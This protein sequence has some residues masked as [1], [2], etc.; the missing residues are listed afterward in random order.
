M[1]AHLRAW[2]AHRQGLDGSLTG[3]GPA[4]VLARSGWARS[5]GSS[6]PYLTLF[7]RAGIAREAVD[8]EV[9]KL[10]LCEL[11]S[12]RGCTYVLPSDD[13]ALAL[14]VAEASTGGRD[15]KT[16]LSLGATAAEIDRL[17]VKVVD[18]LAR[19][20][21]DPDGIKQACGAA[22]RNFGEAGKKKG[23]LTT[24]P[25]ALGRLQ[26]QGHIRRVPANGRLD[27]QRFRYSLWKPNPLAKFK[28]P[29][30]ECYTQL[31]RK[32]WS[33]IGPASMAEFQ[34][35][36]GL[37]VKA[38]QQAVAP[39][40]LLP[41]AAGS[42]RLLLAEHLDEFRTFKVPKE[43]Q[44]SLVS[45]LDALVLLRR[46]HTDLCEAGDAQ[47]P[48]LRS[49]ADLPSHAI[50][51]RGRLIGLW[52]YDTEKE[53]LAWMCF[54]KPGQQL[55]AAVTRTEEYIRTQLG[56]VRSFSLDSP[57]SRAPRIAALRKAGF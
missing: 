41:L 40:K 22:V 5:V 44:Y 18:A 2:W 55:K 29:V 36:S 35:F 7:S 54:T 13:Y 15:L 9:A 52:E 4:A 19:G 6:G 24:L 21:L 37:G 39:L 12:A 48:Q 1:N 56:D 34:W 33:W 38:A 32:Y 45:S 51:D 25:V 30:E 53:N 50:I 49:V 14:R 20:A 43:P 46:N 10:S 27:Q 23:M 42:E 31:A 16:A 28:L 8:A 47:V 3:A 57:K 26:V 17:C 11:P